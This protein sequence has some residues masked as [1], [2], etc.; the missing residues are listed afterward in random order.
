MSHHLTR[1][2]LEDAFTAGCCI[3]VLV[4]TICAFILMYG[5]NVTCH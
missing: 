4:T 2:E 3:A 5:E 1:D